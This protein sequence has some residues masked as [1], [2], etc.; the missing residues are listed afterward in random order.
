MSNIIDFFEDHGPVLII[1]IIVL[2]VAIFFGVDFFD[3]EKLPDLEGT[4]VVVDKETEYDTRTTKDKDGNRH[5]RTSKEYYI[6]FQ[7]IERKEVSY[8]RYRS[9]KVGD[10]VKYRTWVRIGKFTGINY[11]GDKV[12][13]N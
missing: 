9:V 6:Y 12:I 5:T 13:W 11:T 2:S 8:S 3:G 4:T 1:L 7:D 10:E